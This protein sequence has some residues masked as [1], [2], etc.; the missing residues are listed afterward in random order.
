MNASQSKR[1]TAFAPASVAN[2]GCGFD[3]LGFA[4]DGPGDEVTASFTD[5]PGIRIASV[6]GDGGKLPLDAESNTAGRSVMSLMQELDRAPGAGIQL[7]IIKKMPLGS[8]LGSSAASSV[9]AA[10]AVNRLLGKPFTREQLLPFVVEGELAASGTMHADNVSA[11]LLGG[12]ILVRS[13]QP[14]DVIPLNT[15]DSLFCTVIHPQIEIAT[16]KTRLILRKEVPLSKAVSQ[17][18]NVGALVAGLFL[19]DHDLIGRAMED[20]IIEPTR[21]F[22]IPGYEKMKQAALEAGAL[23][24]SISGAGPSVFTLGSSRETAI[25]VGDAAGQVLERLNLD[26]DI[27]VSE[28]N[29]RGAYILEDEEVGT[30]AGDAESSAL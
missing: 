9:A 29:R 23:G 16:K 24:F 21:S 30:E 7:D 22:L 10:V 18:G 19:N 26:Y 14:L 20:R 5:Q 12:F 15:P 2:V 25:E 27:I 17:W 3:V 6:Q 8:G 28:V 1:V 13:N 4:I 11:S